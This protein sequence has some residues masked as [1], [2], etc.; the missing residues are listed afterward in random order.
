MTH[1]RRRSKEALRRRAERFFLSYGY[2]LTRTKRFTSLENV[3]GKQI[4]PLSLTDFRTQK[5]H[6]DVKHALKII[7]GG[8]EICGYNAYLACLE[9]HHRDRN[10][11]NNNRSNLFV[12]CRN[13]HYLVHHKEGYE[14]WLTKEV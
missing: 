11:R 13:C 10:S 12:L 3:S 1:Q 14:E 9:I 6:D 8:C 7:M 2:P 4:K 5:L